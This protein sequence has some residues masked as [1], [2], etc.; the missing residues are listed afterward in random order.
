MTFTIDVTNTGGN[1]S[2]VGNDLILPRNGSGTA[3][4][5]SIRFNVATS[6]TE[7]YQAGINDQIGWT[8][9][10]YV[11]NLAPLYGQLSSL[12]S[13]I[14]TINGQLLQFGNQ[15]VN[16]GSVDLAGLIGNIQV[17]RGQFYRFEAGFNDNVNVL[18]ASATN[19][20]FATVS[21][22]AALA[23]QFGNF[24]AGFNHNVATAIASLGTYAYASNLFSLAG[25]FSSFTAGFDHNVSIAVAKTGIYAT[26]S[27]LSALSGQYQSFVSGFNSNVSALYQS[28]I[29]ALTTNAY[30]LSQRI[31]NLE[32]ISGPNTA[33]IY[34]NLL[35]LSDNVHTIASQFTSF[36]AGFNGNARSAIASTGIYATASNLSALSGQFSNFVAGFNGNAQSAIASTGIYATTSNLNSLSGQFGNFVAGFANNVSVAVARTGTYATADNL[37]AL[38]QQ[39]TTL[40][41]TFGGNSNVGIVGNLISLSSNIAILT[42]TF[43]KYVS[44]FDNNVAIA[45]ARTGTYATASNLSVLAGHF[46]DFV[47]GFP[48]NTQI[49]VAQSGIYATADNLKTVSGQFSNFLA[50]FDG[51]VKTSIAQ[52]GLFATV[53]NLS[54]LS[55]SVTTLESN[56]NGNVAKFTSNIQALQTANS[57]I[58]SQLARLRSDLNGN[59]TTI[60]QQAQT[61]NGLG[62]QYSV[63]IDNNGR[64]SGFGL[65]STSNVYNGSFNS[66]FVINADA[67]EVWNGV[68]ATPTFSINGTDLVFNG[69]ISASS[70]Y[71]GTIPSG[72]IGAGTITPSKLAQDGSNFNLDPYISDSNYWAASPTNSWYI[73][74]NTSGTSLKTLGTLSAATLW[75]GTYAGPATATLSLVWGTNA[76]AKV[77]PG[78]AVSLRAYG[79][80]QSTTNWKVG[81]YVSFWGGNSGN[82]WNQYLGGIQVYWYPSDGPSYLEKA[83]IVPA[84]AVYADWG[85]TAAP[86][87]GGNW[88]GVAGITSV[89]VVRPTTSTQIADGSITTNKIV[90]NA[91]TSAQICAGAVTAANIA[92]GTLS[93]STVINVGCCMYISGASGRL[94]VNDGTRDRVHLG[95]LPCGGY[96]IN[97]YDSG[98]NPLLT[99]GGIN[100]NSISGTPNLGSLACLS[101]IPSTCVTGLGGLATASTVDLASQITGSLAANNVS[102]L[103]CFATLQEKL[104]AA[105]IGTYMCSAAIG[106][107]YVGSLDA[108]CIT[109]GTLCADRICAG[110]ITSS[111]ICVIASGINLDPYFTDPNSWTCGYA[112]T[113]GTDTA[114]GICSPRCS[115]YS[116]QN[117]G[118]NAQNQL[119]VPNG[120]SIWDGNPPGTAHVYVNSVLQPSVTPGEPIT[121]RAKAFNHG[122]IP[123]AA[124]VSFLDA[125]SNYICDYTLVWPPN[126]GVQSKER[127]V[128][129]PKTL[130]CNGLPAV[131]MYYGVDLQVPNFGLCGS[132]CTWAGLGAISGLEIIRPATTGGIVAGAVTNGY[133]YWAGSGVFP[134]RNGDLGTCQG[135]INYDTAAPMAIG[136]PVT[137]TTQGVL[138]MVTGVISA[139]DW[140]GIPGGGGGGGTQCGWGGSDAQNQGE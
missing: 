45:V 65:S 62:G 30:A 10:R 105:N 108:A 35:A 125:C 118:T 94:V 122:N 109:T 33:G 140:P 49:A 138:L 96:G 107:A 128:T 14:I 36:V 61:I 79:F 131:K 77:I 53:T 124:F 123:I 136:V 102:G 126:T 13:S 18:I 69:K 37:S 25:Q 106:A 52:S 129:V 54:A 139:Y 17:L 67:F 75:S 74:T 42:D 9:L 87:T 56:F 39:F 133:G 127:T 47:V 11:T 113:L 100:Y 55:Q 72:V 28:N 110:S 93:A 84:G 2:L 21:N 103:G 116:E 19:G 34:D 97:I 8:D 43:N 101:S 70:L 58:V 114:V 89:Q 98:G 115:W 1:F 5:G 3:I 57:S 99:S 23:G 40:Q 132:S 130:S 46:Q 24:T 95:A 15:L 119:G 7:I 92:T 51:N 78:E 22:V 134:N 85:V 66:K 4:L 26:A 64:I 6:G 90:A 48:G 20:V 80:N 71:I 82:N 91:I 83:G 12:Q 104:S 137:D 76:R 86:Q 32:A 29:I 27:N 31:T 111:K 63:K 68:S 112:A 50:G 41:A 16:L 44:G 81:A 60:T 59:V 135:L 88:D 38:A 73:D 120:L 117:S 121:I